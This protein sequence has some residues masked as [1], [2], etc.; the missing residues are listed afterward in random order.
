MHHFLQQRTEQQQQHRHA[1]AVVPAESLT[2]VT[3]QQGGGKGTDVDAHI[4][5]GETGVATRIVH[6]AEPPNTGMAYTSAA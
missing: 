2:Q 3:A 4:E 5:D 6:A 1:E